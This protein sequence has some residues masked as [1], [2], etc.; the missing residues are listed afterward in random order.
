PG[1]PPAIKETNVGIG[2]RIMANPL[3]EWNELALEA[4]RVSKPGPPMVARSLGIVYTS[5]Y[6]A[7]AAYDNAAQPVHSPVPRRPAAQ[8]S[9]S[10][11]RAAISMA[12]YR[13]LADQ[14]PAQQ[15]IFA[16]KLMAAGLNPADATTD[17]DTPAGV[18]NTA[19]AA[20]LESRHADGSNQL[21]DQAGSSGEPY[22]DYTAYQPVNSA[23]SAL[24]PADASSIP[25]PGRW[26]P[27]S[28]LTAA[29]RMVT[30]GFI[31][32]HWGNVK[33]FAM[34][35]S[36]QF[37]PPAPL[38]PT[39]Q[40]FL[41]QARHIVEV[42]AHLTPEQ[43]VIAEYWADGPASETPPGH[44]A[45]FASFIVQRDK[46]DIDRSVKLFFALANALF[47]AG[48]ATW[49][50]KRYYDYVRPITAIR[51][52][53]RGKRIRAWGG[54][55]RGTVELNGEAWR[56]FQVPT[57]PTPPFGEYTSG[58]SA[59]SMAAAEV[60]RRFTGSDRCGYFYAQTTPLRAD[61]SEPVADAVLR[62]ET[63]TQAAR[64]AGESRLYGG[65]HFYEGNVNALELGRKVGEAA[66]GKAEQLWTG[67]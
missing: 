45:I 27:L 23:M 35:E 20:V 38:P 18:G 50:A 41:D 5:V 25:F 42:Q 9:E 1:F 21:G 7:W 28:F 8:R 46:L 53:F 32:P 4:I 11:R 36:A 54:P 44:W 49:D 2:E 17:V 13:A 47:D 43:K 3:V 37:R 57:F 40:T 19:A 59:F 48:I 67:V 34:A 30:P 56:P 12:A 64:E 33:P 15:A 29:S 39:S 65:I 58:H 52:L 63:F 55:G 6:D 31:A 60:L 22:S 10:N 26:Q 24:F 16:A 66:F 62:W 61:P 51:H 14:F